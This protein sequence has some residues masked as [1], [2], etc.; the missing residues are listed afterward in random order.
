MWRVSTVLELNGLSTSARNFGPGPLARGT[1]VHAACA[2]IAQGYTPVIEPEHA[3]YVDGLREWLTKLEPTIVFTERR[4]VSRLHRLTGRVD[5]GVVIGK[6]GF[7]VDVKTGASAPW[8]GLQLAGYEI[9]VTGH[10]ELIVQ[11]HIA[12]GEGALQRAVLYLPGN[13]S[14]KWTVQRDP[15]DAYIFRAA[16]ALLCYRHDHGLLDYT[17]PEVPDADVPV[18]QSLPTGENGVF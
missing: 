13:G 10:E 7:V 18:I 8:H 12:G 17:D 14:Y 6:D 2:A 16:H 9:L 15:Q 11:Y 5:L 4:I 1:A 3:P